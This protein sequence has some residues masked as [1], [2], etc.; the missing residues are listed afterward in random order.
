MYYVSKTMEISASHH[1]DV[2]GGHKC[3][4]EHGHNYIVEVFCKSEELDADGFVVDFSLIKA[5]VFDVLDHHCLNDVLDCNPTS[6]NLAR[7]ICERVPKCY[8]VSVRE[9][10]SN[11]VIYEADN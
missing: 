10:S 3:A 2:A 11:L 6:E 4:R 5:K 1:L 7:W 9:T 8:K